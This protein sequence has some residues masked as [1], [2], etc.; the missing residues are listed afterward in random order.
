MRCASLSENVCSVGAY[1]E[2]QLYFTLQRRFSQEDS[3]ESAFL[4]PVM[5]AHR[6][7][8]LGGHEGR[9]I[10][11]A[12]GPSEGG[13]RASLGGAVD[14]PPRRTPRMS[15]GPDAVFPPWPPR[16]SS[17][18]SVASLPSPPVQRLSM[19]GSSHSSLDGAG[20]LPSP[21]IQRLSMQRSAPSPP[22]AKS[23]VS[24]QRCAPGQG[25]DPSTSQNLT[26]VAR[27]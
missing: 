25:R 13:G 27:R 1:A 2:P 19:Q 9:Q 24:I 5:P 21:R 26:S 6:R 22:R 7:F 14:I 12:E 3:N 10:S 20:S 8:T 17:L 16:N 4:L 18:D 15:V 11:L 23:T